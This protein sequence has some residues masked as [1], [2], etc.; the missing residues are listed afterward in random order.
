M[1]RAGDMGSDYAS[2][3]NGVYRIPQTGENFASV[4]FSKDICSM[5]SYAT[6]Y[7]YRQ[8][9]HIVDWSIYGECKVDMGLPL[10]YD[11]RYFG[12]MMSPTSTSMGCGLQG[13]LSGDV[14]MVCQY[15]TNF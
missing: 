14:W 12:N 10:W 4:K 1:T 2:P 15:V 11:T 9:S 7:W 5:A 6:E 3:T 13:G 8:I